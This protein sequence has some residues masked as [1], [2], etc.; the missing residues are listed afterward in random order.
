METKYT[1]K[2]CMVCHKTSELT[3]SVAAVQA[4][5]QGAYVQTA[6]PELSASER[7]VLISGT[8]P[9]CWDILF[10]DEED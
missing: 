3:L 6:F 9:D 2:R 7:E 10:S 5:Q 1:T 8:H 4:W